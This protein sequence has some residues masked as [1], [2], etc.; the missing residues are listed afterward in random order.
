[1]LEYDYTNDTFMFGSEYSGQGASGYIFRDGNVGI[2]TTA[3]TAP[4]DKLT[5][6]G[7]TIFLRNTTA[8]STS[9]AGGNIFT[10][11]GYLIYRGSS[12]TITEL[13]VP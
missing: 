1:M 2:G 6:S 3:R 8:P 4:S 9:G 7:G 13:A 11:G 12:G 5:I 10:S